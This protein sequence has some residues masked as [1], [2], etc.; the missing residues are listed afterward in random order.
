MN[1]ELEKIAADVVDAAIKIHKALGPGLLESVCTIILEKKLVERG[2]QVER[3]RVVPVVFE[4]MHFEIGFRADLIINGCF[5]VE[6]KSLESLAPV[7]AKQ[8]LTYLRLT[9]SRLGLLLN[10]GEE[11]MKNGIRRIAN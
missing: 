10:F 8:L 6:L 2:Y 3:E 1:E 11:L 5:I 4:G 9:G 7:H